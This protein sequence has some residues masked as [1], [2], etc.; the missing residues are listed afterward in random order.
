[1]HQARIL[2]KPI[3]DEPSPV[4]HHVGVRGMSGYMRQLQTLP[5][6]SSVRSNESADIQGCEC[7]QIWWSRTTVIFVVNHSNP[8]ELPYAQ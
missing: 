5:I 4:T 2:S 3:G 1:M 7:E 8:I 6:D